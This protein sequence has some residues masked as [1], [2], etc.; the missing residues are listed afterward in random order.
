MY[1]FGVASST[2]AVLLG[3]DGN[4]GGWMAGLSSGEVWASSRWPEVRKNQVES[5][6]FA[7]QNSQKN[8][9]RSFAKKCKKGF[10]WF[11]WLVT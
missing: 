6:W 2:L 1:E 7:L 11:A 5:I 9:C 3:L 10:I 4:G 8:G